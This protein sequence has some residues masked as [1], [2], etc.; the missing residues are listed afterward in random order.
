MKKYIAY[1]RESTKTQGMTGLGMDAQKSAVRM[2]L[3]GQGITTEPESYIEVE[4]GR[5]S[6]RKELIIAIRRCKETGSTLLIAKL[7]GLSRNVVFIFTL[8]EE[9]QQ[10]G[11]DFMALDLPEANTLTLGIMAS[12]AQ[13]DR[14]R[15]SG[16]TKDGLNAI[17]ANIER[18]GFHISKKT[19]KK[20]YSLG[21][22]NDEKRALGL[23]KANIASGKSKM[24]KR[25]D[26]PDFKKKHDFVILLK[27]K[28]LPPLEISDKLNELGFTTPNGKP[29][30][31]Q[32]VCLIIR[33]GVELRRAGLW[34]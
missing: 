14:E 30:V 10:A 16:C 33:Y 20:I 26:D 18:D 5:K 3:S 32:S 22:P 27:E 28:G 23:L 2:F 24:Q 12:L 13:H 8:K 17:K 15:I 29:N 21:N 19:G 25:Y 11:V 34:K 4:N 31:R 1:L 9:L 6:D 7:D